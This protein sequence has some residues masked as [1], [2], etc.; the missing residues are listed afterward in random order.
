MVPHPRRVL[1]PATWLTGLW[2]VSLGLWFPGP[3]GR[4]RVPTYPIW[5]WH[6]RV[7]SCHPKW[8]S[9]LPSWPGR[10]SAGW[11]SNTLLDTTLR[12]EG[13]GSLPGSFLQRISCCG[14]SWWACFWE[15]TSFYRS[16]L[17]GVDGSLPRFLGIGYPLLPG[18]IWGR[19]PCPSSKSF[20]SY[21]PRWW[22]IYANWFWFWRLG[23]IAWGRFEPCPCWGGNLWGIG[24]Y[25]SWMSGLW[26]SLPWAGISPPLRIWGRPSCAPERRWREWISRGPGDSLVSRNEPAGSLVRWHHLLWWL[27]TLLGRAISP[28]APK[29][30]WNRISPTPWRG[31]PIRFCRKLFQSL[32]V[33]FFSPFQGF[34]SHECVVKNRPSFHKTRLIGPD[35][36]WE[37][38]LNSSR[39]CFR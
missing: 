18:P 36:V 3:L 27:M 8:N 33:V 37:S 39:E 2:I 14:S 12:Q 29:C 24:R 22:L 7:R 6:A 9:W 26:W 1:W 31:I 13:P 15:Q 17:R 28:N 10:T 4:S 20:F 16:L 5:L 19:P 35:Y 34:L 23:K 30:H 11:D 21:W 25:R 38:Y 32:K